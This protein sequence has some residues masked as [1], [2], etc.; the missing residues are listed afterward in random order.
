MMETKEYFG[1]TGERRYYRFALLYK[2]GNYAVDAKCRNYAEE[3]TSIENT[4]LSLNRSGLLI[5]KPL[6]R[7]LCSVYSMPF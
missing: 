2:L 3:E 4:L 7:V 5:L 1:K 6:R